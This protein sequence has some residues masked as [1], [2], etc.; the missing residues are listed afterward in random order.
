[1][2]DGQEKYARIAARILTERL[3]DDREE[4][5]GVGR[6]RLVSAL[7]VAIAAKARRR[8][9][10]YGGL[11]L[12]VAA[13]TLFIVRVAFRPSLVD[14]VD[15]TA[16]SP[17]LQDPSGRNH[18]LTRGGTQ[19]SFSGPVTLT[20]G[21]RVHLAEHDGSAL[22][23]ADGTHVD[24]AGGSEVQIGELGTNR[25]ILLNHGRLD[26]K[27]AKL[28]P[29]K[30]FLVTTSDTEVEVHG[31]IFTVEAGNP[32]PGCGET[33][34]STRV[35]VSEGVVS[36]R[37]QGR[38]IYLHKGEAWPCPEMGTPEAQ[39]PP[40]AREMPTESAVSTVK[41]P[42]RVTARSRSAAA[43]SVR[44]SRGLEE[45]ASSSLAEQ[46]DLFAQA[47]A[48]EHK[49]QRDVALDKLDEL[50]RRFPGGP[51]DESARAERNKILPGLP[52]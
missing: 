20:P 37:N 1:M 49:K 3:Q 6:D 45:H 9:I 43:E 52:R 16:V 42:A 44:P 35:R 40:D 28:T 25:R 41:H 11:L 17:V 13:S 39:V 19:Q 7:A 8:R 50:L 36:V 32:D 21:D 34:V 4:G 46:N 5:P 23:F 14:S 30:R 48:A 38:T 2:T 22:S 24:L 51:L 10:R 33:S 29:G 12:A 26:L 18:L 47:M 31:T 15:P 27:V